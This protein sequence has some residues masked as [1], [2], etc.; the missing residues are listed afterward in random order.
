MPDNHGVTMKN[1]FDT[2]TTIAVGNTD[3]EIFSVQRLA[4]RFPVDRLPYAQKILLENLLRNEDGVNVTTD[5]IEALA[6]WN[7]TD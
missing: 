6:N 3:F 1:S 2:R 5:D 7:A 4:D